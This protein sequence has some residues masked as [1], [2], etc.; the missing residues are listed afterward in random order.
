ME[1]KFLFPVVEDGADALFQ[2]GKDAFIRKGAPSRA[3]LCFFIPQFLTG[4]RF[5]FLLLRRTASV[6]RAYLRKV[7]AG[8][9]H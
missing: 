2:G 1:E 4:N 9:S 5:S 3:R 6:A 7:I 8:Y